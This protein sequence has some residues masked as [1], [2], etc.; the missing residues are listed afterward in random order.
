MSAQSS[1]S[2]YKICPRCSASFECRAAEVERCQCAEIELTAATRAYLKKT[3]YDCLCNR[4]L[5]EL[6]RLVEKAQRL[7]FPR[8][9]RELVEGLHFYMENGMFVFT[10]FY[11]IQKGNCCRSGCRHCAY[12]FRRS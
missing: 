10:E 11:H 4:C 1:Q 7:P 3:H 6:D 12:G 9:P 2:E 8:R 5:A